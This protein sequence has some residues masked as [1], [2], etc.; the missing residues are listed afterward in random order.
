VATIIPDQ[1][2]SIQSY[3]FCI[4]SEMLRHI[5]EFEEYPEEY[6]RIEVE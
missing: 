4:D 1:L 2:S 6:G 5:D 3:A